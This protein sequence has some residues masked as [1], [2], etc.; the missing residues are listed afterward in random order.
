[1]TIAKGQGMSENQNFETEPT[2]SKTDSSSCF[3]INPTSTKKFEKLSNELNN[4]KSN[5]E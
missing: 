5:V 3:G 1:M 2:Q 4:V